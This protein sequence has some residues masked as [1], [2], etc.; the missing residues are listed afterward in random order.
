MHT[1]C[2]LFAYVVEKNII[3]THD[4]GAE[5]EN[6]RLEPNWACVMDLQYMSSVPPGANIS[7][8]LSALLRFT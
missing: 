2:T 4:G 5:E 8:S 1:I 6:G 7:Q 3:H